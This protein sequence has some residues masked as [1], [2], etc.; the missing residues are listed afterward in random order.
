MSKELTE[1]QKEVLRKQGQKL[2][3]LREAAKLSQQKLA[4][5]TGTST[6][7]IQNWEAGRNG[8]NDKYKERLSVALGVELN[9]GFTVY[10]PEGKYQIH[11][12]Y[13]VEKRPNVKKIIHQLTQQSKAKD[14]QDNEVKIISAILNAIYK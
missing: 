10:E 3:E 5:A 11:K 14:M 4:D 1:E 7:A 2:R 9:K 13:V 8:I 12:Q 6:T